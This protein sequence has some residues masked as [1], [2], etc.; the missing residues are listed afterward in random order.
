MNSA[1]SKYTFSK[2]YLKEM[3]ISPA[4][5]AQ[6][7]KINETIHSKA[8]SAYVQVVKS[9]SKAPLPRIEFTSKAPSLVSSTSRRSPAGVSLVLSQEG[10]KALATMAGPSTGL[11]NQRPAG[12]QW[13]L[14]FLSL[15]S[16]CG[17]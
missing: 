5:V 7:V 10:L 12:S 4:R 3:K 6:L 13:P 15:G 17:S 1:A 9:T 8:A 11:I 16:A 14:P 2:Q